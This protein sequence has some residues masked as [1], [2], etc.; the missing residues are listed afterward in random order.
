VPMPKEAPHILVLSSWYPSKKHPFL[1]NFVRRHAQLLGSKYR[2][3]VI[4]LECSNDTLVNSIAE[5]QDE[6]ITEIKAQYPNGSKLSRFG[7]R[8]RVFN[9]A[10]TR[11]ET[12][13]LI[14]G[15][16][17]LPHGWMFSSASKKLNAPWIWV[18]HGSYF[19]SDIPK[20]W[21][22][23]ERLL[24]RSAISK[25]AAIVA[26][27][28]TLKSDM[29]QVI[30]N[31]EIHVI[32]NHIDA[33][34]F[35]AQPKPK[36]EPKHF[37]HV[38]TLDV[39]TK[40]PKGIIDA[41]KLLKDAAL[42][43]KMTLVSDEDHSALKTYADGLNLSQEVDFVGPTSWQEMPEFYHN[44]DAFILNSDYE[45][46]SIVLAE[47]LS[48]GTPVISTQ[49]GIA[50]ELSE[51]VFIAVEKQNPSSLKSAMETI[52]EGKQQWNAQTIAQTG[53]RYHSETILKH[54]TDLIASYVG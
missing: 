10:L 39:N 27:S 37:L 40:N 2:V 4:N 33:A 52:I 16:V 25:S 49:V 26:V 20:R 21:S 23:R 6:T 1:G 28:E 54:W 22:P 47:A 14:I 15:H 3:T 36:N 53:S 38:S 11:I 18:E 42:P 8:A 31:A 50:N 13:D 32:G 34:L 12:V 24:R 7:N 5:L 45:T 29:R 43:F 41:C 48:T 9:E 46:F 30:P 19:R 35:T 51:E 44:A 17:L